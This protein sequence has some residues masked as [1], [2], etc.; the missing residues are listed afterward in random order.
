MDELILIYLTDWHI[1]RHHTDII[2]SSIKAFTVFLGVL[3]TNHR[4][5]L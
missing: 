2:R 1:S 4:G 5:T 3:H